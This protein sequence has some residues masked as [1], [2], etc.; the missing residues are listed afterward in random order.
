MSPEM[1]EQGELQKSKNP[2]ISEREQTPFE[3]RE[4]FLLE[5]AEATKDLDIEDIHRSVKT[6]PGKHGTAHV[7]K[8]F[9]NNGLYYEVVTAI[10]RDQTST[11]P[12]DM[13]TAWGTSARIKSHNGRSLG[14]FVAAGSPGRMFGPPKVQLPK[15]PPLRFAGIPEAFSA[16][17]NVTMDNDIA[18]YAMIANDLDEV[19]PYTIEPGVSMRYGESRGIMEGLGSVAVDELY[20]RKTVWLEGV[21]PCIP[22]ELKIPD[23]LGHPKTIGELIASAKTLQHLLFEAR[24]LKYVDTVDPTL[25][26]LI[27]GIMTYKTL[28]SGR[29]GDF[30]KALPEEETHGS[31]AFF[32]N[33]MANKYPLFQDRLSHVEGMQTELLRGGHLTLA[34][35][36]IVYRSMARILE[37][38]SAIEKHGL[39]FADHVLEKIHAARPQHE[40]KIKPSRKL[41]LAS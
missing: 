16:S 12:V 27:P 34:A 9:M 39:D 31:I 22:E 3:F 40:P 37:A 28:F 36:E 32:D 7:D 5:H 30:A 29:A 11:I 8:Y 26:Y 21:D 19:H 38:R 25:N 18:A 24:R 13:T 14:V 6:V 17:K 33:S 15:Y 23:L 10:P 1:L 41:H 4:G 20:G 2:T 35:R